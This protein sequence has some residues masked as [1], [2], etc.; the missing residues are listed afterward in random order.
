MLALSWV[1]ADQYARNCVMYF[2]E[3]EQSV[4]ASALPHFAVAVQALNPAP[5]LRFRA[6]PGIAAESWMLRQ[7]RRQ[8]DCRGGVFACGC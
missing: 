5:L 3:A 6:V 8:G 2:S 4:A 7:I 1:Q